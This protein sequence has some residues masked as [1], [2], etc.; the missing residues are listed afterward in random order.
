MIDL[1]EKDLRFEVY[2]MASN[3][4]VWS[5]IDC[6]ASVLSGKD[7]IAAGDSRSYSLVWGRASSQQDTCEPRQAAPVGAYFLHTVIGD[8]ASPAYAFN[9]L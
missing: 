1:G 6:H 8:N 2:D 3:Q 5:D 7:T 9:L 4:R